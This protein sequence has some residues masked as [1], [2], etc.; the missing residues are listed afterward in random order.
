[1]E[2]HRSVAASARSTQGSSIA[3]GRSTRPTAAHTYRYSVG[4]EWQHGSGADADQGQAYGLGYDLDL[5]SNF[6]FFLDDPVHGDQQRAG[7][8]PLRPGVRGCPEA[9][10]RAGAAAPCRTRSACSSATTMCRRWRCTTPR[11]AQRLETVH[12]ASARRDERRRVRENEVEWARW[13]RTTAGL[14][15]DGSRYRVDAARPARTA[16]RRPPA[17]S[18]RKAA[19]RSGRG[20]ATEFYVNAGTGFHS[21][22]A[23]GTTIIRDRDGDPVDRVTP[24]VRAKGAE[25]GVRTVAIPHLQKHGV[26]VDAAARLGARLQRR[27]RRDR[28]R[29]REPAIRRRVRELL[30]P[31]AVAH[32]RRRPVVVAGALHG[33]RSGRRSTCPRRSAR[34]SR[35]AR[36]ST[37][38]IG[39][40]AACGCATSVR[41]RSSRTTRCSSKATTPRQS[42][43]RVS[44]ARR[45]CA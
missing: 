29:P 41:A 10:R 2:R 4:G 14:R 12:D 26:A 30:Q 33:V 13:L 43:G 9:A 7:R 15:A 44:A 35:A 16:A 24:L 27:R 8:S 28:A 45:T 39:R 25:V 36:A 38:S 6:T 5:I 19:R 22:S 21:N 1:M 17:S 23:L 42:R 3:S 37:T 18:A 34:S 20:R 31:D 40:S 11:R 32:L